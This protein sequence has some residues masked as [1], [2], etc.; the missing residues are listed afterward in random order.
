[1]L[2]TLMQKRWRLFEI[3]AKWPLIQATVEAGPTLHIDE[4]LS[5][6]GRNSPWRV[7]GF[8]RRSLDAF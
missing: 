4:S 7:F 1:M 8:L 6:I 5:K 2:G 3:M